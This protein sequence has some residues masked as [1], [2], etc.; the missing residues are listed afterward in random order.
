MAHAVLLLRRLVSE[1]RI[2]TS[3]IELPIRTN[4]DFPDLGLRSTLFGPD[5]P[6]TESLPPA[7][8][9][10]SRMKIWM[11]QDIFQCHYFLGT[12]PVRARVWML[13]PYLTDDPGMSE[14]RRNA[15]RAGIAG[16]DL[17]FL[18]QY[19]H[20]VPL[21]HDENLMYS[22]VHTLCF[23]AGSPDD[24]GISSWEMTW[25]HKPAAAAVSPVQTGRHQDVLSHIYLQEQR[26]MEC[27]SRGNYDGALSA[28]R[29]LENQGPEARIS[30]TLR[31]MK[32]YSIAFNTLCRLAARE[33][34]VSPWKINQFS[35][36]KCIQIENAASLRDLTAIHDALL[37]GYCS[38]VRDARSPLY[39][40]PVRQMV[41]LIEARFS[42]DLTLTEVAG[43]LS[44]NPNYLSVLF[45]KE[46]GKTFSEYLAGERLSFARR[47]L[48]E[49]NM[50]VTAVAAECGIMDS[51]YFSRL[52]KSHEH[53]TPTQFRARCRSQQSQMSDYD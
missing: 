52:F 46:T 30:N 25:V 47:L 33:G 1:L 26:M 39:S 34:G 7:D 50:P 5:M 15:A 51:N 19:Y 53:M 3:I 11:M 2:E 27:I 16:V 21:I 18:R 20:I 45:K 31:D 29:K 28:V 42:Q 32:N 36:E 12:D 9:H 24:A 4:G 41:S 40:P 10:D 22:I 17:S 23:Q 43:M 38:M 48:R 13:G 14:I 37:S 35:Q 6:F 44:H 8:P 49:T